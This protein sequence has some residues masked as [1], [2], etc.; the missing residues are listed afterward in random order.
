MKGSLG[1]TTAEKAS[2]RS[3]L[4]EGAGGRGCRHV[5]SLCKAPGEGDSR[6]RQHPRGGM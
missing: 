5:T 2:L 4:Q 6:G 3:E 1:S